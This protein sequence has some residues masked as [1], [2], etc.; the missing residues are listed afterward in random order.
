MRKIAEQIVKKRV[1]ILMLATVLLVPSLVGYIGTRINYDILSYLPE[2]LDSIQGQEILDQQFHAAS[3]SMI[4][5]ENME[6]KQVD[7][8]EEKIRGIDGVRDVMGLGDFL[9]TMPPE[10]V[11]Q[12][13]RGMLDNGVCQLLLVTFEEGN[14]S[15]RTLKA[16][17]EIKTMMNSQMF[18]GGLAAVI[19]D[20][21]MLIEQELPLYVVVAVGLSL[22]VLF[23]GLRYS[24]APLIFLLG[25]LYAVLYNFGTNIFLGEV[26]YITSALA[27]ILQLAVSMDFSIFLLERYDEELHKGLTSQEAMTEAVVNTFTA[28]S[29]SSLTTIAGFLAMCIMDL[30]LGTDM[31]VVM[32]KGVV[33]GVFSAVVILPALILVFDKPIHKHKHKILIPKLRG[34]AKLTTTHYKA[35]LIIAVVLLIP[36][37]LAQKKTDVYY[38]LLDSLPQDL[39]S[40]AGTQKLRD[41]FDMPTTH[42]ILVSDQLS[43]PQMD[44]VLEGIRTTEGIN[45]VMTLDKFLG[46]GIPEAMLPESIRSVFSAGGWKMIMANS[47]YTSATPAQNAQISELENRVKAID[48]TALITGE[49]ALNRDLV[50]IADHD[51]QMVNIVSILAVFAIIAISFKSLSV[52]IVLVVAIE[53]AIT[54]NMGIPYFEGETIP[55]IASIVIGTI[56]LGATIDYAILMM[57]RY[58]E[59]RRLGKVRRD[60]V[61]HAV[62][63]CSSSI[64]TSGLCFF[65]ATVGVAM[66]SKIDLIRSLCGMLARGALI[67]MAVILLV[68]PALLMVFGPIVEKTSFQFLNKKGEEH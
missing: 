2:Q 15:D 26:S 42:F 35:I 4:T 47:S 46:A 16:V 13:L 67:S 57:T 29:A 48:P 66:V 52:P 62:Y 38:N 23:L 21:K 14:G 17:D 3:M 36:F 44:K 40:T 28:I 43:S 34:A 9:Q 39:T 45:S 53:M 54:I 1:L 12:D 20:T 5:V 64:L 60:A 25:I 37:G 59:E 6:K 58:Q 10:M 19:N 32:A 33:L 24:A 22:A 31:G 7:R 30:K 11:P 50:L 49:G 27:A 55:F 51:I 61:E 8:I 41:E 18:L 56:Q 68:L 65:S 63:T